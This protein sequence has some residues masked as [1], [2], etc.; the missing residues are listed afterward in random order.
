MAI[1]K[2]NIPKPLFLMHEDPK[3]IKQKYYRLKRI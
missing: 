1:Q 2:L 3:N